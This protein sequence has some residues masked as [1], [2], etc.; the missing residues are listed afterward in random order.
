MINK[1][2]KHLKF[3]HSNIIDKGR[4]LSKKEIN[5]HI[6]NLSNPINIEKEMMRRYEEKRKKVEKLK[7]KL[8]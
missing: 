2:H 3:I 4:K 5:K 7:L 6:N 1:Y 8:F